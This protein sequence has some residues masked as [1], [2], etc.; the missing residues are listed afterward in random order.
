DLRHKQLSLFFPFLQALDLTL[1]QSGRTAILVETE[2][3]I[4]ATGVVDRLP[5][6]SLKAK[7]QQDI[8]GKQA[9]LVALDAP[10]AEPLDGHLWIISFEFLPA[11]I[12]DRHLILA[13]L[14]LGG[15]P[16][17]VTALHLVSFS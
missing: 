12:A 7:A 3:A 2:Q 6:R 17:W 4:N 11:Q 15:V 10:L 16:A 9:F 1:R 8:T 13:G 5:S 14:G